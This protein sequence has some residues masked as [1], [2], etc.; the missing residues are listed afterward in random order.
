MACCP[1]FSPQCSVLKEALNKEDAQKEHR[2]AQE[3]ELK[4]SKSVSW[5]SSLLGIHEKALAFRFWQEHQLWGFLMVMAKAI[6]SLFDLLPLGGPGWEDPGKHTLP[7][8]P[9]R[10]LHP[11]RRCLL[12]LG[13][14]ADGDG[15]RGRPRGHH[16]LPK[17][18]CGSC[19][20]A[21]DAQTSMSRCH[22]FIVG[23]L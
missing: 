8:F 22:T 2:E 5:T 11:P 7:A 18:H 14:G 3:K 21:C 23:I 20:W 6:A 17:S 12:E 13:W 10:W 9:G 15:D 1:S 16:M 19:P 4:L